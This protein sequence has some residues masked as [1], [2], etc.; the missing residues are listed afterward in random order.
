MTTNFNIAAPLLLLAFMAGSVALTYL[1][2]AIYFKLKNRLWLDGIEME[3]EMNDQPTEE[4]RA[5][6]EQFDLLDGGADWEFVEPEGDAAAGPVG[7]VDVAKDAEEMK[8]VL[9]QKLR[10]H[11]QSTLNYDR[12]PTGQVF[13]DL[14]GRQY[15]F[16]KNPRAGLKV[17]LDPYSYVLPDRVKI[18]VGGAVVNPE[19]VPMPSANEIAKIMKRQSIES[20][21]NVAGTALNGEYDS[22]PCEICGVGADHSHSG[23]EVRRHVIEQAETLFKKYVDDLDLT[24]LPAEEV[25]KVW[26][27]CKLRIEQDAAQAAMVAM[28]DLFA[29][30]QQLALEDAEDEAF[31]EATK[32]EAER[33]RRGP[34]CG[35]CEDLT[36]EEMKEGAE[37][38]GCYPIEREKTGEA[39]KPLLGAPP[40]SPE[41]LD[42]LV[43]EVKADLAEME[44]GKTAEKGEP[45]CGY[46]P[47]AP[48]YAGCTR[49]KGHKGPCAHPA[50]KIEMPD[51]YMSAITRQD[52]Q[53]SV[54]A[55]IKMFGDELADQV[56]EE[57]E[58]H[59]AYL[60]VGEL[61]ARLKHEPAPTVEDLK[62]IDDVDDVAKDLKKTKKRAKKSTPKKTAKKRRK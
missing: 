10:E 1:G 8:A 50:V 19:A 59:K 7:S 47:K 51:K 36:V 53:D 9:A 24:K 21:E 34:T 52:S 40:L 20:V 32:K 48:G 27:R 44:K 16:V 35:N 60:G 28:D 62:K 56:V 12:I 26:A 3:A 31:F 61:M 4:E 25:Q 30:A 33:A 42:K 39:V 45:A 54:Y 15:K 22:V 49:A 23:G 29:R 11:K 6:L 43:E 5:A 2:A 13:T 46:V 41:Q 58:R 55:G 14:N 17:G 18:S 37:N 38:C 57:D